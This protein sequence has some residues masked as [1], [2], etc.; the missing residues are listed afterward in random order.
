M[1]FG[2][3]SLLSFQFLV[4]VFYTCYYNY[5]AVYSPGKLYSGTALLCTN[6]Q[7]IILEMLSSLGLDKICL[8]KFEQNGQP[9][10]RSNSASKMGGQFCQNKQNG[11]RMRFEFLDC[12]ALATIPARVSHQLSD[13]RYYRTLF[14][15]R[16]SYSQLTFSTRT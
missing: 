16:A 15:R 1:L 13:S 10:E 5:Y 2:T 3:P 9:K 6:M 7:Y 11:Q 8:A 14:F 12:M 4:I